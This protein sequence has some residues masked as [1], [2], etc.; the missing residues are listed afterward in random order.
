MPFHPNRKYVVEVRHMLVVL[1]NVKYWKVFGNDKQI[2]NFLQMKDEFETV[3]IDIEND[4]DKNEKEIV[5]NEIDDN[6]EELEVLQ[7]KDN[8]L[9]RGLV[10]LEEILDFHDVAKKTKIE[11]V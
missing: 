8:V 6:Q 11:P 4:I 2:E 3:N 9:P 5:V 7:L 10:P 1:D